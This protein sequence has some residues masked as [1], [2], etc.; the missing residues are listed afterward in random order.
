MSYEA[1]SLPVPSSSPGTAA[2]A[3]AVPVTVAPHVPGQQSFFDLLWGHGAELPVYH[4]A[5]NQDAQRLFDHL[6]KPVPWGTQFELARGVT[7][8]EWTWED[9]VQKI[10]YFGGMKDADVLYKVRN[11]MRGVA[12][13]PGPYDDSIG[14]VFAFLTFSCLSITLL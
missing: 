4:I 8:E 9:I 13:G 14:Y 1:T 10:D 11:I 6:E 3:K 2:H 5:Y 12:L 7:A